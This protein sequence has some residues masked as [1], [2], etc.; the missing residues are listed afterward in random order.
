MSD[1]DRWADADRWYTKLLEVCRRHQRV[2]CEADADGH[3]ALMAEMMGNRSRAAHYLRARISLLYGLKEERE[4]ATALTRLAAVYAEQGKPALEWN[5]IKEQAALLERVHPREE[6]SNAFWLG[7]VWAAIAEKC[8]ANDDVVRAAR[9]GMR[10]LDL[11][12]N[13]TGWEGDAGAAAELAGRAFERLGQHEAA[14]G[15]L[16]RAV[17]LHEKRW[18]RDRAGRAL[19]A[20]G[21]ALENKGDLTGARKAL[22]RAA[23]LRR[24]LAQWPELLETLGRLAELERARR[25]EPGRRAALLRKRSVLVAMGQTAQVAQIDGQ[26]VAMGTP[27][28]QPPPPDLARAQALARAGDAEP[29]DRAV[30]SLSLGTD[31]GMEA[32]A[33]L[34]RGRLRAERGELVAAVP[35]L[36]RAAGLFDTVRQPGRAAEALLTAAEILG[37]VSGDLGFL[38]EEVKRLASEAGDEGQGVAASLSEAVA[39]SRNNPN[40]GIPLIEAALASAEKLGVVTVVRGAHLALARAYAQIGQRDRAFGQLAMVRAGRSTALGDEVTLVRAEIHGRF[41]EGAAALRHA[42]ES[43]IR[44]SAHKDRWREGRALAVVGAFTEGAEGV[45]RLE[46]AAALLAAVGDVDAAAWVALALARRFDDRVAAYRALAQ[47]AAWSW[48]GPNQALHAA[49]PVTAF[50]IELAAH[51]QAAAALQGKRA[52]V[53][54]DRLRGEQRAGNPELRTSAASLHDETYQRVAELLTESGRLLEAEAVLDLA[55]TGARPSSE[56]SWLDAGIPL[57]AH[58]EAIDQRLGLAEMG[59]DLNMTRRKLLEQPEPPEDLPSRLQALER[60]FAPATASVAEAY[61]GVEEELAK[62]QPSRAPATEAP[63]DALRS[64][65]HARSEKTVAVYTS[66]GGKSTRLILVTPNRRFVRVA[67]FGA[68]E[69][70]TRVT[71]LR[72]AAGDPA[73]DARAAGRAL[74]EVLLAP[75]EADLRAAGAAVILWSLDGPLRRAP[76]AALYDGRSWLAE[77]YASAVIGVD[78]LPTRERP[79]R[80]GWRVA[81]FATTREHFGF[82]ALPGAGAEIAAVTPLPTDLRRPDGDFSRATLLDA[83]RRG[84]HVIHLATHFAFQAGGDIKNFLLLGDGSRLT[85]S[86]MRGVRDLF[87]G[88][89]LVVL[90]ACDTATGSGNGRGPDELEGFAVLAQR[91]GAA[92][93]LASLWPIADAST[94]TLM[95]NF[96]LAARKGSLAAALQA[97]QVAMLRPGRPDPGTIRGFQPAVPPRKERTS[98]PYYWAPFVLMGDP[99]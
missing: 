53:A 35:D 52:V 47:A 62:A 96:Y 17:A 84:F 22:L 55:R 68:R 6:A 13:R 15:A 26:L 70:G 97:A 40:T 19:H 75:I 57:L 36:Q 54:L 18:R 71:A 45:A 93:V 33:R 39:R 16:A 21:A 59:V 65:L 31:L 88:V 61:L 11:L 4:I 80:E 23:E 46:R 63:T 58:E 85:V 94:A 3:I 92:S 2:R 20:L 51:H 12:E 48:H 32:S 86:D 69:V 44:A 43:L 24:E 82:T 91:Q 72:R 34:A 98:H 10:A 66:V 37:I 74:H 5:T 73:R 28:V 38:A 41:G 89:E 56:V 7:P 99:R 90:S 79:S 42:R 9:A 67:P 8:E 78:R 14:A 60:S 95:R 50:E 81:A 49:I 29:L 87:K 76:V 77:R 64:W 83:L 30:A 27:F 1:D 25:D